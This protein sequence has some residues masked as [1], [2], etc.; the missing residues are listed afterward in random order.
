MKLLKE[1]LFE[2]EYEKII[3]DVDVKIQSIHFNSQEVV[4]SSLFVA[5]KG[6]KND[7][8]D[9]IMAAISAGASVV[10][11]EKLPLNIV[12]EITYVKVGDSS[13][14]L[15]IIA[16]NF[17]D[18]PSRKIKLVGVTGTN[19]KTST[20]YY[21]ASLFTSLLSRVG[22]LSTIENQI[23]ERRFP[24]THTTPDA[25]TINQLFSDMV[26]AGCEYCFMEV[27][28]HAI[29]Q[30]RI[31]GLDFDIAVFTNISRDHLDYHGTFE[32]YL[33]TK[34]SFFDQLSPDATALINKDDKYHEHIKRDMSA[35]YQEYG[36]G[37]SNWYHASSIES[38]INGLSLSLG[39]PN[40]Q[41][42]DHEAD[43]LFDKYNISIATSLV[44]DFN[45]YNLL[46]AYSVACEFGVEK[47]LIK[48]GL[49]GIQAVPGRF[50]VLKGK[51]GVVGI[52]DYAHTP[53][54]LSKVIS[55][56]GKFCDVEKDLIIV[57]GCGGNR[58]AGK[59]SIMAKI[60]AENSSLS[61]FT[62]DNPRFE[63]P[64]SILDDMC[65]D[66]ESTLARKIKR[67]TNREDAIR[68]AVESA[69]KGEIVLIAGKGHENYQEI[70]S[71]RHP[72]DDFKILKKI[73]K[74]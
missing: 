52:V 67:I 38:T 39:V 36:L 53:D 44:G 64:E 28:S 34:K 43:Y 5:N 56:I 61:I 55:S 11:C 50:N 12:S 33:D 1:L 16:S 19:G 68:T 20:V 47:S 7:G 54:A 9:Y 32:N 27:S 10:V 41:L 66:L 48:R 14:A 30:N 74:I 2:L 25:I 51:D 21:L 46:A 49:N 63:N 6:V 58:D 17:F 35:K 3:G 24:S 37:V 13:Y 62:S 73:L 45:A 42:P 4:K 69:S 15:A 71:V 60:A 57:V 40:F 72:F 31:S 22:M 29:A 59:R 23:A 26:D 8:H 65:A 70:R 18:N